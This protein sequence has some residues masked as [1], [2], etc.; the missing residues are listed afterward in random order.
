[1]SSTSSHRT[2]SCEANTVDNMSN[3]RTLSSMPTWEPSW[4]TVMQVVS[5]LSKTQG[6][7]SLVLI[8]ATMMR[9]VLVGEQGCIHRTGRWVH[10][11][12]N[13]WCLLTSQLDSSKDAVR[14]SSRELRS[15]H[16]GKGFPRRVPQRRCPLG[17]H[18]SSAEE[19]RLRSPQQW[20]D[21]V[22]HRL[23]QMGTEDWMNPD[24]CLP[25]ATQ[26]VRFA[27]VMGLRIF[28]RVLAIE[29]MVHCS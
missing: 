17:F 1:M 26:G 27:T 18:H 4:P 24:K 6:S 19:H 3:V 25:Q 23:F 28:R 12:V 16:L 14:M 22:L 10:Q 11:E 7:R 9:V 20:N 2:H 8:T 15:L 29:G 21:P 13:L 5:S